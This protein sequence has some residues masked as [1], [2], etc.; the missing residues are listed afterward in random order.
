[1]R[2]HAQHIYAENWL[3]SKRVGGVFIKKISVGH[4]Q[5]FCENYTSFFFFFFFYKTAS[6]KQRLNFGDKFAD[7]RNFN[8][9][10]VLNCRFTTRRST[11]QIC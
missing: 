4:F 3:C 5:E 6:G 11:A 1:M 8:F 10:E 9:Q 2:M 7:A